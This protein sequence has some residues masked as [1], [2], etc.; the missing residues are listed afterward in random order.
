[1]F[2]VKFLSTNTTAFDQGI[3]HAFKVNYRKELLLKLLSADNYVINF[4]KALTLKDVA[5][6]T[7]IA[8]KEEIQNCWKNIA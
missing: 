4:L 8:W 7:G 6:K 3:T 5:Y 2:K 1:M